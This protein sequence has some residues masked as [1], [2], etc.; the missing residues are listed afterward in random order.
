MV[1]LNILYICILKT[2][3]L[4]PDSP[5]SMDPDPDC[6][7]VDPA[8]NTWEMQLL[9][10]PPAGS[11]QPGWT[12]WQCRAGPARA[13]TCTTGSRDIA[14]ILIIRLNQPV[15]ASA[16]SIN[17][18]REFLRANS[19]LKIHLTGQAYFFKKQNKFNNIFNIDNT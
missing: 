1:K 13:H 15:I 2:L 9:A 3:A 12:W 18:S 16:K 11:L 6:I 4:D 7:N 17:K 10:S 5:K 8:S 19:G 14:A